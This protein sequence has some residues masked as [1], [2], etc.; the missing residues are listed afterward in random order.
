[1]SN[2]AVQQSVRSIY[3]SVGL[4]GIVLEARGTVGKVRD[5]GAVLHVFWECVERKQR[6]ARVALSA[7]SSARESKE[8]M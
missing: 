1:M 8:F 7:L 4:L 2:G 3:L 5:L 6:G